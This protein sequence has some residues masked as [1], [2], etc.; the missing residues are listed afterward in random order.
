MCLDDA[1]LGMVKE[2]RGGF[3]VGLGYGPSHVHSVRKDPWKD[4]LHSEIGS[5][6]P[7]DPWPL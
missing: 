1:T 5:F 3:A 4:G 7:S 6:E 2:T